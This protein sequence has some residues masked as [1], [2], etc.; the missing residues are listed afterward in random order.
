MYGPF[1][2]EGRAGILLLMA[3]G[4]LVAGVRL[5]HRRFGKLADLVLLGIVSVLG[6]TAGYAYWQDGPNRRIVARI[7]SLHAYYVGTTGNLLTGEV[8]YVFFD[9][10]ATDRDVEEFTRLEGID[11]LKRLVFKGTKL[12]DAT[13][14]KLSRFSQLTQLFF[15]GAHLDQATIDHLQLLL[16]ACEIE[17]R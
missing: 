2:Q 11:G 4:W 13:A 8:D 15:E 10:K 6:S 5:A 9:Y 1:P 14:E 16:P 3:L 12:T 17:V 7:E